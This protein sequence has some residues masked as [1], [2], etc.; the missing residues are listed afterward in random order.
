MLTTPPLTPVT[1]PVAEPTVAT[2]V[3]A[4]VHEPPV[5]LL[6]SV[7]EVPAHVTAVPVFAD[8]ALTVTSRVVKQ[9]VLSVYV[10]VEVPDAT[11]VTV[12]G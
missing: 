11:P 4:L 10:I 5:L 3:L 1:T 7:V 2:A 8:N 9:P 6:L 12:P